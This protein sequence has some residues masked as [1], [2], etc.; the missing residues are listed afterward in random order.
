M[1]AAQKIRL[2]FSE[3]VLLFA[4]VQAAQKYSGDLFQSDVQFAAVQAAQKAGRWQQMTDPEFAAVQAAQKILMDAW[5]P[6]LGVRCRSGSPESSKK[7]QGNA[8][9]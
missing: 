4:A 8:G 1:Q 9:Y 2:R 6:C 7:T 3:F 5:H